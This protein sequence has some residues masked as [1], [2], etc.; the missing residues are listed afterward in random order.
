MTSKS[1]A[2]TVN[3]KTESE[4]WMGRGSEERAKDPPSSTIVR[5]YSLS[6]ANL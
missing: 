4:R 6:A 5:V 2:S 1:V 3:R